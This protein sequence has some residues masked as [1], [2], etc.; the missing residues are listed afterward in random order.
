MKHKHHI[1]PK[2]QGGT[3][4]SSNLKE[5]TLEEHIQIHRD[6]FE[7]YGRWQDELAYKGLSG[8]LSK[9]EIW[10]IAHRKG[11]LGKH[12]TEE[13]KR[14]ISEKLKGRKHS[15]KHNKN[16]SESLKGRV[17]TEDWK[18]KIGEK[19]KGRKFS[20]ESRKKKSNTMKGRKHTEESKE[21]MRISR[22]KYLESLKNEDNST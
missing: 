13:S 11:N 19:S 12:H 22:L 16:V 21:K 3:D 5:V 1:I 6:L 10:R 7:K 14:N 17:F 15:D 8:Q 4:D 9:E 18:R 20:E 2:H